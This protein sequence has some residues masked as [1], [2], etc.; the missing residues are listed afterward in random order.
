MISKID[1]NVVSR[2][3]VY[4]MLTALCKKRG[5]WLNAINYYKT[6]INNDAKVGNTISSNTLISLADMYGKIQLNDMF[7]WFYPNDIENAVIIWD[8][9]LILISI[10]VICIIAYMVFN[11]ITLYIPCNDKIKIKKIDGSYN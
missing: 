1:S 3:T 11:R 9:I 5:D 8:V 4:L 7:W 2:S 6:Y 10:V